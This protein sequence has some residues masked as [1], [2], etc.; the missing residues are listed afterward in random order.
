MGTREHQAELVTH[1]WQ[2]PAA[3]TAPSVPAG[4]GT[5]AA[6]LHGLPAWPS[7]HLCPPPSHPPLLGQ[8]DDRPLHLGLCYRRG[9]GGGSGVHLLC[10]SPGALRPRRLDSLQLL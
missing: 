8:L 9:S 2:T 4:A 6:T 1:C 5:A 7:S 10:S 3:G